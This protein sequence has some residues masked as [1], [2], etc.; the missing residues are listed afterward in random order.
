MCVT[1]Q[2]R[3]SCSRSCLTGAVCASILFVEC[4]V[5]ARDR[6]EGPR[7]KARARREVEGPP[8]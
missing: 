5:E 2:V 6:G 1:W 4:G 7:M 3:A 8:P